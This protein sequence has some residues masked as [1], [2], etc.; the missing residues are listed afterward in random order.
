VIIQKM[1]DA[2]RDVIFDMFKDREGDIVN[3]I[4]QRFERGNIIVNLG[5]TDAILPT[6][7]QIPR[8]SYRQGDRI[9]AHLLE[10]RKTTKEPQLVLS[11]THPN[12]LIKLFTL[13]VPEIAEGT[14]RIMGAVREPGVRAKIAVASTDSDVDPVGACVG[15]KGSRVQNVVQELQGEKIDIVPWSPDPAKFASNALV[16]AQ[17]SMV[18]V[19]ESRRA[20]MVIVPDD[21]LSL[22]IGRQGQNVRLASK[23]V[24]WKIDVKSETTY[25]K[26]MQEGYQTLIEIPGLDEKLADLLYQEGFTSAEEL[27]EATVEDLA[28]LSGIDEERATELIGL[29]QSYLQEKKG[30]DR[31]DDATP[32]NLPHMQEEKG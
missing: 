32:E 31:K 16:P 12:F 9:R 8:K 14:V 19:D 21:Q 25:A 15:M 29:A 23:L 1:K 22:A 2:E 17:V 20:L 27:A 6:G 26:L 3:G 13:E 10:V 7:E 11:R 30:S 5:R 18:R 28:P 24:G 4:V